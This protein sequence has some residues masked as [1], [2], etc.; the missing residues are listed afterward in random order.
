MN[1]DTQ[2]SPQE[3]ALFQALVKP[4]AVYLLMLRLGHPTGAREVADIL[5]IHE[6]TAA[7]YLRAL[8]RLNLVAR[9]SRKGG[10]VVLGG[11]QLILGGHPDCRAHS[12]QDD[13][14]G[15]G[16]PAHLQEA[17]KIS[18]YP[19]NFTKISQNRSITTT[20]INL[21]NRGLVINKRPHSGL[22]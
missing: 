16:E 11:G 6:Q 18:L 19:S 8:A 1:A 17:V 21:I 15:P 7:R 10:Y 4:G 14:A 22:S 5:G 20:G 12:E 13:H 2:L 3:T 9:T